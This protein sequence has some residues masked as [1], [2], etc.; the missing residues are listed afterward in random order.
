MDAAVADGAYVRPNQVTVGELWP[1]WMRTKA[2][3]AHSSRVTYKAAW[4]RYIEPRW[5]ATPTAQVTK[6]G[7][8]EWIPTLR[9]K[10]QRKLSPSWVR[11]IFLVL[12][13]I[14]NLAVDERLL[15]RNPLDN[16]SLPAQE[17]P[18]RRYLDVVE[19]DRLV[20]AMKPH[21]LEIWVLVLTGIRPGEMAGLQVRDLDARRGRLRISRDVNVLGETDPT[22]TKRHRDVPVGGELLRRLTDRAAG[23]PRDAWL[24]PSPSGLPWTQLSWR[25]IWESARVAAGLEGFTTYELR[26]TAASVAIH[27]GANVKTV[28][29]ML[30]HRTAAMTLDTYAHLWDEELDGLPARMDTFLAD[31]RN[32]INTGGSVGAASSGAPSLPVPHGPL[33]TGEADTGKAQDGKA[34]HPTD[35]G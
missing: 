15:A 6:T 9:T 27:A 30:G 25:P 31:Q 24:L 32:K 2:G 13:G 1:R 3:L 20:E 34:S 29:R 19:L 28:Q 23:R 18:A 21:D 7:M 26:H 8:A 14:L 17:P 33:P 35:L 5:A 12:S 10:S 16:M 11:K 4:N 22:K